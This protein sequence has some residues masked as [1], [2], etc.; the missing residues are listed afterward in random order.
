MLSRILSKK[1]GIDEHKEAIKNTRNN[2]KPF[3]FN[4]LTKELSF[5]SLNSWKAKERN[6]SFIEHKK[7]NHPSKERL[8]TKSNH[9]K[10]KS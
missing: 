2:R 6:E 4:S 9:L 3:E 8:E 10:H 1:N 5:K 7:D